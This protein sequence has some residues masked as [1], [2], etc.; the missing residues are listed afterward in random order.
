MGVFFLF[1]LSLGETAVLS[2]RT[3]CAGFTKS[4]IN[5][6]APDSELARFY[7]RVRHIASDPSSAD[8]PADE[9]ISRQEYTRR[10]RAPAR[11]YGR[12]WWTSDRRR[13]STHR[14]CELN[15]LSRSD[16]RRRR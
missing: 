4:A 12:K 10:S 7:A 14:D 9:E 11:L 13:Q 5:R 15:Y 6:A 16:P 2:A 1:A 3:T 8:C